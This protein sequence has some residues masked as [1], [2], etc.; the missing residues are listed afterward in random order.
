MESIFGALPVA[1]NFFGFVAGTILIMIGISRLIKT[2]QDGPRGPGGLGTMVT[3]LAGGALISF[4]P[5]IRTF[6][7]SLFAYDGVG[8]FGRTRTDAVLVY[9][10]GMSPTEIVHAHTVISAILKFMILVG[11]IS[12]VRGIFIVRNVAEGNNK[13]RSWRA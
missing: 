4:N 5:L 10:S 13:P 7:A 11:L 8:V 6:T 1:M 3:F 2:A 12:F 9:T